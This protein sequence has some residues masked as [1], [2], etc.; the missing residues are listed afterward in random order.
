MQIIAKSNFSFSQLSLKLN[1]IINRVLNNSAKSSSNKTKSNILQS[2]DVTGGILDELA[3]ITHERR[4]DGVFWEG[5]GET[6]RFGNTKAWRAKFLKKNLKPQSTK[7]LH[8][9]GNLLNS[10]RAK[11]NTMNLAGYGGL[12]HEGYKVSGNAKSWTVPSRP[13]IQAEVD[14]KT[15]NLF[16]K[17]INKS[18]GK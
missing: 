5:D 10:I 9:T 11:K 3:E 6:K 7:P 2:K 8:Y 13:F 16:I 15:I 18:L 1:D 12:H 4:A 14:D 17:D